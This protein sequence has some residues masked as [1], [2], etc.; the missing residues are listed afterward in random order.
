MYKVGRFFIAL[1]NGFVDMAVVLCLLLLIAVGAYG[2]WD[3]EQMLSTADQSQ[4]AEYEPTENPLSFQEL[5]SLNPDVFGWLKVY[6]TNI[7][8]PLLQGEDNDKYVHTDVM[9]NYSASGSLFLDYR[10]QP[11][12]SDFNSIIY[13]HHMEKQAMFGE[14]SRF[15]ERS[16]FDSHA[17]G[18]VYFDGKTM[19]IEFVAFI[20]ADAYDWTLYTPAVQ[21]EGEKKELLERIGECAVCT[22]DSVEVSADSHLIFLSTCTSDVTNGRHILVGK[23]GE[24]LYENPFEEAADGSRENN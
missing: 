3:N 22:R 14:L 15:G 16:Y 13:G 21:S 10:N 1:A 8:Y 23:L 18:E 2:L 7:S 6:G 4:Y 12:F 24:K 17:Y 19:G 20:E 11:D 5:Q 9:G